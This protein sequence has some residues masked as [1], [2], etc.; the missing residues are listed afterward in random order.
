MAKSERYENAYLVGKRAA[1]RGEAKSQYSYKSREEVMGF[2]AGYY[3][4]CI[5]VARSKQQA[6][7]CKQQGG[8]S[9]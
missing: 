5:E 1:E 3:A 6:N 8:G 9:K 4:G 2:E 7:N